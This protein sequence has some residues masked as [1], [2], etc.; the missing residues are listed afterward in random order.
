M[1]RIL[2]LQM[3]FS[4]SNSQRQNFRKKLK[5]KTMKKKS[6]FKKKMSMNYLSQWLLTP[7]RILTHIQRLVMFSIRKREHVL[8][9][10]AEPQQVQKKIIVGMAINAPNADVISL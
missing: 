8:K 2:N 7:I 1:K 9:L 4:L 6:M 3:I 10:D 5:I